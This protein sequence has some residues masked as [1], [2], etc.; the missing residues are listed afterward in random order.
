[1]SSLLRC[2][3]GCSMSP[4]LRSSSLSITRRRISSLEKKRTS[5]RI[6]RP[7]K[8]EAGVVFVGHGLKIPE[9]KIDDLAGMDLKGK[10]AFYIAGAP[11][12]LPAPLAAHAQS[13]AERWKALKDAGAIGVMSFADPRTSDV[14]WERS[15]LRRLSPALALTDPALIDTAGIQVSIQ[16]NPQHAVCF[17]RA[18]GIP[19]ISPRT[20][21]GQQADPA[22]PA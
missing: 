9:A 10:I 18:R 1:M 15:T 19:R 8:V 4:R 7:R 11:S 22:L 2:K 3:R 20:A 16:L 5:H 13:T 14:P 17:S 12:H 21:Q 6:D